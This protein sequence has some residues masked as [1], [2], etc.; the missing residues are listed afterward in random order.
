MRLRFLSLGPRTPILIGQ[1]LGPYQIQSLLGRGGMGEVYRATDTRLGRDVALKILPADVQADPDRRGRF[2]REARAIA[3]ID[4]PNVVTVHAVEEIDERLVLTME[5]VEGRTLN[6]IVPENGLPLDRLLDLAIPLA[7]A[8][9]A[10]HARGV[11]HRDLKPANVMVDRNGRIRV[12]DFGLAKVATAEDD[13]RTVAVEATAEGRVLG[14]TSYMSPEQAEGKSVDARSDVFSLGIL[15]YQMASGQRPFVGDTPISTITS[16]LRDEPVPVR[17]HKPDLPA[18]LGRIVRRCLEKDP[19]QRYD[20]AK[21]LKFE[22]ESLLEDSSDPGFA[23]GAPRTSSSRGR[24]LAIGG[25]FVV[26][27]LALAG[28]RFFDGASSPETTTASVPDPPDDVARIVVFPFENL[29]QADDAFFASGISEEIANRLTAVPDVRVLSRSSARQYDRTSRSMQQIADDLGV[30]Y[31]LEGTVRW[32]RDDAGSR[33]RVSP[34]LVRARED[35]QVWAE[36]FDRTMEEIFAIQT[37]IAA[38]V[39]RGIGTELG[40]ALEGV[41][42]PTQDVVAYQLFLRGQQTLVASERELWREGTE[43]LTS[44]VE[45]DPKFGRAWAEL[46]RAQAGY[47][48]FAWDRSPERILRARHAVSRAEEIDPD[49]LWTH[50]AEGYL[51]Y[52]GL[53]EYD[54]ATRAFR[55]AQALRPDD[56]E[57]MEAIGYVLRRQAK[58]EEALE[59]MLRSREAAP[60]NADLYGNTGE[61]LGILRRYDEA[62]VE[63]DHAI[64][65]Q[66]N[67]SMHYAFRGTVL[68]MAGRIQE[69]ID[70]FDNLPDVNYI[71]ETNYQ[72]AELR[73]GQL[74][75]D[76]ALEHLEGHPD[77]VAEQFSD[78]ARWLYQA[79]VIHLRD[80]S[81]AAA[82]FYER[83]IARIRAEVDRRP[84]EANPTS[85][86]GLALSASGAHDEGIALVRKSMSLIPA[87]R[88]LWQRDTRWW[89][90]ARALLWAGR[91]DEAEEILRDLCRRP[92]NAVSREYLRALPLYGPESP[93]PSFA[94]VAEFDL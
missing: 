26:L 7:D 64:R 94:A 56:P 46:A 93:L 50:L 70:T 69:A 6:E 20:S 18:Q 13:D 52:W 30:D 45:R 54:E 81:E 42:T 57:T 79:Q 88:D 43:L 15:L 62:L 21:G 2:E 39:A 74:E 9:A 67:R 3:A 35:E 72:L 66:P 73:I 59:W 84:D 82:P 27:L 29:G 55:R 51:A 1:T 61:T 90:L 17:E 41:E 77:Y 48:H 83:A 71:D 47:V 38:S 11:V 36:S 65:L 5:L 44:A 19:D 12:L 28:I 23:A 60:A 49:A 75:F 34:V 89:D 37:E 86:L 25:A 63:L 76:A 78:S 10:A 53:R 58:F 14:T 31:V 22:L 85:L 40:G 91:T 33:V 92:G 80:G 32:R 87:D 8:L 24:G 16:I 68:S 4:H